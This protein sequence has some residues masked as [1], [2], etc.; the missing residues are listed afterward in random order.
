MPTFAGDDEVEARAPR[1]KQLLH[2]VCGQDEF[3]WFVSDEATIFD[4][5]T[6][7]REE[8]RQRLASAYGVQIDEGSLSL[9]IWKLLDKVETLVRGRS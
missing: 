3:P 9:P 5:C 8:I 4:V 6:L 1:L 2:H 7:S